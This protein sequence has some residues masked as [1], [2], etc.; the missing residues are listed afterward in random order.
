MKKLFSLLTLALLTMSA[1][2][3][4]T[5]TFDLTSQ[6]GYEN[7]QEVTTVTSGD[8]TI[9]FDKGTNSNAPK[10][11]TSGNAVRVYGGGTLTVTSTG[12]NAIAGVTFTFGSGDGSNAITSDVGTF[13]SPTWTGSASEVV[14]TIGGTSGHRRF[15]KVE[16]TL[17]GAVPT[18]KVDKP[19]FT[20][21]GGS[22]PIGTSQEV[23]VESATENA[24]IQL[25]KVVEGE[26]EYVK[27]FF[28]SQ[29]HTFYVTET[30][31]YAAYAYKNGMDNSDTTHVTFTFYKPTCAKPTFT[32]GNGTSFVQGEELDVTISCATEGAS[33]LYTVNDEIKEGTAPVVV[34][35]TES[36]TITAVASAEGY[37]DSDEATASYTMVV[38][39][40][41][42]PVFALVSDINDL[43]AGDKII[44][45]NSAENGAAVAMGPIN[46]NGRNFLGKDV[47]VNNGQ[48][49]TEDASI[50]TLEQNGDY[51]NL[52]TSDKYL[53]AP[54]GN[55]YMQLED[56]VDGN[57]N[58]NAAI[59]V[60]ADTTT[61]VF[62]G[63][64]DR[65]IVRYNPNNGS[66]IF[67]CYA[68]TSSVTGAIYIYKATEEIIEVAAPT[69]NPAACEFEESI[70]VTINC[71]TEGATL[72]YVVGNGD[73]Q[74]ATAPVTVTLTETTTITAYAELNGVE[75][76]YVEAT[77]TLKEAT[78]DITTLAQVNALADN[79]DF[80]F[81]GDAVVTAQQGSYL[82]LRDESGYGLIYGQINGASDVTFTNG[83]VLSQ[84]WTA[85]K[86][87]YNGL[88][89]Y[90]G[91]QNVSAS[92][93]TNAELAA[94]QTITELS[95]NMVNAYVQ[96][97]NVKSFTVSGKNVTATLSDGS[98]MVMYNQF[99][100]EIPTAE[101]DYTVKG[102]VGRYA[103][104]STDQI[105]LYII[106]IEGYVPQ[107]NDVNNIAE[108]LALADNATFTM[109]ND[110]VVTYQNGKN[111]WI[112]DT[113]DNSGLIYGTL[114]GTF[115]NGQVL[116]DGWIAKKT[117]YNNVPEFIEA[118]GIE[119]AGTETRDASPFERTTITNDN[120]NEY[121]ILK[122]I[123]VL[124]DTAST[125]RFYN[126]ADS[127][128]LYNQFNLTLDIENGN[129]YD[130][131]G[132]VTIYYGKPELYIISVTEAAAAG[133]RG[134]VND[135]KAVNISDVTALIDYLLNPATEINLA[136]ADC[137]LDSAINISDVTSLID[138]LLS[139]SW[140][141][142][143]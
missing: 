117:I 14:F 10:Y 130:V 22:F 57:G 72:H 77:Y 74:T 42:G 84:G 97:L 85:T 41:T 126:A 122:D 138:Y 121:V 44:L 80:E 52:K 55:N 104:N 141:A 102:A 82:W 24:T 83:Q 33:I 100:V 64:G 101:G 96:V 137:N 108:A 79:T 39:T 29:D 60:T 61:I 135:D 127:L 31:E 76:E 19:V 70:D 87:T 69:F 20:P 40:T 65:K 53:Y 32:P 107:T 36:A 111:L 142:A 63:N 132:I 3:Q 75:S 28:P 99:S 120:V 43:A 5:V 66:P 1:W 119:A 50:I 133:L 17:G 2:A 116:S 58:A 30:T 81:K 11:Y 112:R 68:P 34:T 105:Q 37:N 26:L 128:V 98:T 59:T 125:K 124:T 47:V 78:G 118:E 109:Y 62:Q 45:V 140:P 51:W 103:K 143:E 12:S 136:N 71:A 35:L 114:E 89:E 123:T 67:S 18:N 4:T 93:N 48:V 90:T 94:I 73:E 27:D 88:T 134:D 54:G 139:G 91:S 16:V 46:S 92:G 15:A 21:N 13:T 38:P 86:T 95:A 129:N 110:V 106:S 23:T 56:A 25:Y 115:E 131:V 49:Q 113:E 9:T 8:V 6:G 7:G